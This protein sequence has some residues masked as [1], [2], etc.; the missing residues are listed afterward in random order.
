[1]DGLAQAAAAIRSRW[2]AIKI[3]ATSGL[4]NIGKEDLPLG[5]HFLP[6]ITVAFS[7]GI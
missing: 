5:S 7:E 1:M 6:N 3:A 4:L 2:P